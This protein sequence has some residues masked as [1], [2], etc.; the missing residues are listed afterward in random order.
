MNGE[1]TLAATFLQASA[2]YV[3]CQVDTKLGKTIRA[4]KD[5]QSTQ[6]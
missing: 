3:L 4:R 1:L 6:F 2:R 5:N